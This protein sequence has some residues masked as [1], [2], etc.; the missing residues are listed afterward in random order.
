MNWGTLK[1][2]RVPLLPSEQQQAIGELHREALAREAEAA[3]LTSE[4]LSA[5]A[6]LDL[7]GEAARDRRARA[8]PPR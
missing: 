5:I 3:Q 2:Q 1:E 8:K 4:A 7:E 6:H